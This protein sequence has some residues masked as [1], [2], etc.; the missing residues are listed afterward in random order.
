MLEV[1][2]RHYPTKMTR[3]QLG[4]LAGFTPSGGTYANY[5]GTLKRLGFIS[6][7]G[8]DVELTSD[9]FDHLGSDAPL[10]PQSTEEILAM[11]RNALRAGEK[12]MFDVLVEIRPEWM[13]REELGERTG[14]TASGGTFANYLGTLARNGLVEKQG[15]NIR[16]SE[17]LF[18]LEVTRGGRR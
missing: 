18:M 11:W 9:G 3:A 8:N 16:A 5:F 2:A 14:F 6:V 7:N 1:L 15:N 4:T 13:T 17:T 10:P 12:A